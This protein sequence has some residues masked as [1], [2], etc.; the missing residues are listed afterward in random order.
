MLRKILTTNIIIHRW[1]LTENGAFCI[2]V[3]ASSVKKILFQTK[4]FTVMD[5]LIEL[6][7]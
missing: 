7:R 5:N 6:I 2:V 4:R 3:E 1:I